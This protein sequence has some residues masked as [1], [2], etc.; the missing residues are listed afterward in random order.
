MQRI[1]EEAAISFVGCRK[2][3]GTRVPWIRHITFHAIRIKCRRGKMNLKYLAISDTHLGEPTSLLSHQAG[4]QHLWYT[5]RRQLGGTTED[6]HEKLKIDEVI[7]IG[8]IPDRTL[9]ATYQIIHQTSAFIR[10]L[11]GV[12]DFKKLVYCFGNHDHTL[13]SNY[14]KKLPP[15]EVE[16][17]ITDPI[18]RTLVAAGSSP[19]KTDPEAEL[20]SIF[21]EFPYGSV[22]NG[23]KEDWDNGKAFDFVVANPMYAPIFN[24]RIY[25]FT[26]GTHF[27]WDVTLPL[28][29]RY[30][31][32]VAGDLVGLD[33][34][35]GSDLSKA[36]DLGDLEK[37]ITPF[38]DTLWAS[39][40]NDPNP[41]TDQLYHFYNQ[42]RW[43]N[44]QGRKTPDKSVL[45]PR[46]KLARFNKR[47]NRLG[48]KGALRSDSLKRWEES[49]LKFM[50]S[51]LEKRLDS[52]N[53]INGMT[54][55][56][57][58]T[59]EGGWGT[60]DTTF[61]GK[62][63]DMRIYN[64][65]TWIVTKP[66][67]HP[68]CHVFAVDEDGGEYL[69]DVTYKG[70]KAGD[71]LLLDFARTDYEDPAQGV[72]LIASRK[73]VELIRSGIG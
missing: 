7:L 23:I 56:Y 72:G 18:G 54:F 61:R 70:V 1:R 33:I 60:Y 39:C 35:P 15:G 28:W 49:F 8:D 71:Q 30:V 68:P 50:M 2:E 63:L 10:T 13:W 31:L 58:D 66:R 46:D 34:E 19:E 25:I 53:T 38:L 57:G 20:L 22:W 32:A 55:V 44:S 62:D 21:F 52:T 64:T 14:S 41:L 24:D 45:I 9:S 65:G 67:D 40:G 27:R 73:L 36:K 48:K 16:D 12:A 26:H 43:P 51:Y 4:L 59:H 5:L 42:L 29:A 69:L 3:L 47:I 37:L 17:G 6:R 11:R